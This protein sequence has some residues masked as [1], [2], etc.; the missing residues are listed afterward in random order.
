MHSERIEKRSN[1]ANILEECDLLLG[2]LQAASYRGRDQLVQM[3]LAEGADINAQGGDRDN[4]LHAASCRGHDQ[5][6]RLR[7]LG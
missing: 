1:S 7:R 4:V 2:A 5:V 3:L 6:V